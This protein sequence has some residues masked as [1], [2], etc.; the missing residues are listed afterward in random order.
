MIVY[1]IVYQ[2]SPVVSFLFR[3]TPDVARLSGIGLAGEFFG[4]FIDRFVG[5]QGV[6]FFLNDGRT[7]RF[8]HARPDGA[9]SVFSF[10]AFH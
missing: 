10:S 7:I 9:T 5:E 1:H 4:C 2:N 6:V 3:R 8:G